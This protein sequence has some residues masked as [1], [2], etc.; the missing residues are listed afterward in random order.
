M[1][2]SSTQGRDTALNQIIERQRQICEEEG[3]RSY[4]PLC[5]FAEG[6]TSNNRAICGFKK[7][8]FVGMRAVTP[9]YVKFER[10]YF[11]PMCDVIDIPGIIVLMFSSFCVYR[12]QL[13]IMPTFEPTEFML[14]KYESKISGGSGAAKDGDGE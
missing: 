8:A 7:G 12:C 1:A 2:R 11:D 3:K 4:Q 5:L 10:S 14:K 13:N 9:C 6:T